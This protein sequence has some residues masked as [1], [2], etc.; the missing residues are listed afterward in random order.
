MINLVY[1][2]DTLDCIYNSLDYDTQ[3]ISRNKYK[4]PTDIYKKHFGN[5]HPNLFYIGRLQ[6]RKR[7]DLVIEAM[8]I[9]KGRGIFLNFTMVGE[10]TDALNI[11]ELIDKY[12]LSSSVWEYGK[13]FDEDKKAELMASAD[14][15]I[16]PGNIGLTAMDSLMFG[17]PVITNDNFE[18]QMPEFEAIIDGVNGTFFKDND[19][20]DLADKIDSWLQYAKMTGRSIISS[21][22]YKPIDERYNPHYQ[23]D[24]LKKVLL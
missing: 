8:H 7:L 19:S 13:L 5:N 14:I 21:A 3:L 24:V 6:S 23:I 16:S 10:R 18:K 15:C 20:T 22:C 11:D 2:S 9:L 4:E 12:N 1:N 17:L